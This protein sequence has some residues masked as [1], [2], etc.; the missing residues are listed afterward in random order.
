M[1][2]YQP[3]YPHIQYLLDEAIEITRQRQ[4]LIYVPPLEWNA[5]IIKKVFEHANRKGINSNI[6]LPATQIW[7]RLDYAMNTRYS[8]SALR[9]E[10]QDIDDIDEIAR[11][12]DIQD[13]FWKNNII[14][15][16]I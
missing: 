14:P 3:D 9:L 16:D 11:L 10:Q 6:W 2:N 4:E 8:A 12:L 13:V 7:L 1:I 15:L 5:A